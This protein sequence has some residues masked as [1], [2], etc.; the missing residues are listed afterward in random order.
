MVSTSVCLPNKIKSCQTSV[1]EV[2]TKI[3]KSGLLPVHTVLQSGLHIVTGGE[4]YY[5]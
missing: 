4:P 5:I 2:S 3:F 1:N